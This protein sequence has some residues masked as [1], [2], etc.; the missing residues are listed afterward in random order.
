[1][2]QHWDEGVMNFDR[3]SVV[4]CPEL[5][6]SFIE[7]ALIWFLNPD[8]NRIRPTVIPALAQLAVSRGIYA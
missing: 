6:L 2:R 8:C 5:V 7:N 3:V 1:M 4:E